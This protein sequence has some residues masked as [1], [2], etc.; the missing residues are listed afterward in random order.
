MWEKYHHSD[1]SIFSV[2]LI[3]QKHKNFNKFAEKRQ[4]KKKQ[5]IKQEISILLFFF[6]YFRCQ[7]F[8]E[9]RSYTPPKC[10]VSS[11]FMGFMYSPLLILISTKSRMII[12]RPHSGDFTHN[13]LC[14][15]KV[16]GAGKSVSMPLCQAFVDFPYR[17]QLLSE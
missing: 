15:Q 13:S 3:L 12:L 2:S 5:T 10:L 17:W 16:L 4:K 1:K 7:S 6:M 8:Q 11:I 9:V 14:P